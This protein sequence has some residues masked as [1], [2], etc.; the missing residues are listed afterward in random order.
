[1]IIPESHPELKSAMN[2][3]I[4]ESYS[5]VSAPIQHA[6]ITAYKNFYTDSVQRYTHTQKR[7]F[8]TLQ[9]HIVQ[10]FR[11]VGIEVTKLYFSRKNLKY[12]YSTS[13]VLEYIT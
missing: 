3:Y 6:V 8:D 4:S 13:Y 5:A 7:I 10:M 2:N 9:A 12:I 1:M 11:R